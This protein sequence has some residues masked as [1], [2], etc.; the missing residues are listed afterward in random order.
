MDIHDDRDGQDDLDDL[1]DFDDLDD[2][3]NAGKLN[4]ST[5]LMHW[6]L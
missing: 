2:H 5:T 6:L 4:H 1:D 3:I